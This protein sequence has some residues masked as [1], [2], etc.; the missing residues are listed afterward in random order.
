MEFFS[1]EEQTVVEVQDPSWFH[2]ALWDVQATEPWPESVL[3][4]SEA[5]TAR[6]SRT[7]SC[8]RTERGA[9]QFFSARESDFGRG[10][11]SFL[12]S[13][14]PLALTGRRL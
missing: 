8:A 2:L 5:R 11:G 1:E 14:A 6:R 12:V 7:V 13:L 10:P 9:K 3:P 4:W